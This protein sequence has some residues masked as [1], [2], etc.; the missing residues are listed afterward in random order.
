MTAAAAQK[1]SSTELVDIKAQLAAELKNL[2]KQIAP[3]SG[4]K[5][6]TKGKVFS[7]P[8]ATSSEGPI[9]CVILD[10]RNVHQH[11]PGVYDAKKPEPPNCYAIAKNLD[12]LVPLPSVQ[13]PMHENC[14][15]CPKNQFGSAI[16][17]RGKAC[18]NVVRLAIVPPDATLETP[19]WVID[20]S[21]TAIRNWT[22]YTN[23]LAA[24]TGLLPIEVIS[25][26]R[27]NP[28]EAYPTLMF[29]TPRPHD[30]LETMMKLREVAQPL[31]DKEP[32]D[33]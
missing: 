9:D 7:F 33:K 6:G 1:S 32:N 25:E 17:G 18:K 4:F 14:K 27:F 13:T 2:G 16:T 10:W 8:D 5:V 26:L 11:Y 20:V 30:S 12:A 3:P 28:N 31:L 24:T 22:N 23:N 15:E 19:V 21:P 29:G